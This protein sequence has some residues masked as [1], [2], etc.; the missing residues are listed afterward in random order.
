MRIMNGLA[1]GS[2]AL[3]LCSLLSAAWGDESADSAID[4]PLTH[5]TLRTAVAPPSVAV[6]EEGPEADRL[7]DS[8]RADTV[9]GVIFSATSG[10]ASLHPGE[11]LRVKYRIKNNSMATVTYDF[12]T[13][14]QF[15]LQVADSKGTLV[16]SLLAANRCASSPTRITL[17]PGTEK[18]VDLNAPFSLRRTD[19]LRVKAMMAGYPLSRIQVKVLQHAAATAVQPST[20][21]GIDPLKPELSFNHATKI[22]TITLSR[23]QHLS[24]SAFVLT[25]KQVNKLATEKFLSAGTHQISFNNQKLGDGIVIF[26]VEG[27]GFSETRTINLA[28]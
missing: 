23:P 25:G 24:I 2:G 8:A 5:T 7:I 12:P 22:L 28:P 26:K 3:L 17:L 19:T 13:S 18:T 16:Y 20:L 1:I 9:D 27:A 21:E 11:L 15:D 10:S 14:C 6:S 4:Q